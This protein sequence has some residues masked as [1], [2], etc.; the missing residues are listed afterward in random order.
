MRMQAKTLLPAILVVSFCTVDVNDCQYI[1]IYLMLLHHVSVQ[2]ARSVLYEDRYQTLVR[3]PTIRFIKPNLAEVQKSQWWFSEFSEHVSERLTPESQKEFCSLH[4]RLLSLICHFGIDQTFVFH[5]LLWGSVAE[6]LA[7]SFVDMQLTG[8]GSATLL[9]C[10]LPEVS[11]SFTGVPVV[12]KFL[13]FQCC[14]KIL[15]CLWKC[16]EIYPCCCIALD[17]FISN[18][19]LSLSVMHFVAYINCSQ[20]MYC[21]FY[22]IHLI[23]LYMTLGRQVHSDLRE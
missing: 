15:V 13:K 11:Y 2:C 19:I 3:L 23:L 9:T 12:L 5:Q 16:P 22:T 21:A 6:M 18:I 10:N 17:N 20:V 7:L 8:H 4:L 14:P 1:S